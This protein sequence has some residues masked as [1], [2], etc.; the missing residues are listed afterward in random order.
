MHLFKT[1]II[2]ESETR[3]IRI[4]IQKNHKK[5]KGNRNDEKSADC[6]WK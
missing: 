1:R 5:E 6:S 3:C 4:S 2:I